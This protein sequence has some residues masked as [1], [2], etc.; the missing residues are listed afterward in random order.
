MFLTCLVGLAVVLVSLYYY[1]GEPTHRRPPPG[2]RGLPILGNLL[3]IDPAAPHLSLAQLA[4]KYGPVCALRMGSVYTVLVTDPRLVRQ[5]FARD[6]F[7]GRAP[8]YLTHGIM[9][10]YGLIAAEGELWKEQRGFS[11]RC[12]KHFG[13]TRSEGMRR[14]K[15]ERKIALFID[16]ALKQMY[17]KSAYEPEFDPFD[18]LHHCIGNLMNLIVFG[19]VYAEDDED[20]IFLQKAQEEGVKLIGVAGPLNFLP[21]L[22]HI[23]PFD[24]PMRTILEGQAKTHEIYRAIVAKYREDIKNQAT[25]EQSAVE[26]AMQ[27][28]SFLGNF[29]AQQDCL[30]SM[31]RPA[32]SFTDTQMMYLL[33][34]VFGAGVD[35]T[36]ATLRWFL[37]FMAANPLEQQQIQE[38]LDNVETASAERVELRDRDKLIRLE[39]AI[40]ETQRLRSVVPTG[41][42]HGTTRATR[43]GDYHVP[44][45]SMIMPLQWAIHMNPKYWPEP[46]KFKP[47]RFIADDGKLAK[48]D[49]FLPF[50]AGK[51]M[52]VGDELARMILFL[53]AGN[54]L[55]KYTLKPPSEGSIDLEGEC[56]ITLLP[57]TQKI[58]FER[59]GKLDLDKSLSE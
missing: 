43:I 21:F 29:C 11:A 58:L 2:P 44:K 32:G 49:A 28:D 20:W 35:T 54:I 31:G 5:I 1:F 41:I 45:G 13:M 8:L 53:F 38:H 52:C 10:G 42:P 39:A 23:P 37:L 6:D 26:R 27:S 18:V 59:R 36:L 12:L 16:E 55:K 19:K 30:E 57:K 51:R 9:K 56:G 22:R 3:Q 48:P 47:E 17:V 34:D 14:D 40:M 46:E 15:M 7:S 4:W 33:A 24:K 50:Q 25:L